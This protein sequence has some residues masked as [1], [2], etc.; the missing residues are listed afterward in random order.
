MNP[1]DPNTDHG[2]F[3]ANNLT[4]V[5][6]NEIYNGPKM[7]PNWHRLTDSLSTF[8]LPYFHQMAKL[9]TTAF[10]DLA[11]D[12]FGLVGVSEAGQ[13]YKA[14]VYPNPTDGKIFIEGGEAIG[15]LKVIDVLGKCIISRVFENNTE[16]NLEALDAGVYTILI[17]TDKQQ[18]YRTKIL[19][20]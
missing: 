4:A 19:K 17:S 13:T 1:G 9:A 2:T 16:V 20:W 6:I 5:G 14:L 3:W 10:L 12:S 15:N 18:Y 7:N 11:M 8:N